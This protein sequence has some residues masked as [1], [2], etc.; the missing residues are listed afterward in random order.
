M[1][2]LWQEARSRLL[3]ILIHIFVA[4]CDYKGKPGQLAEMKTYTLET[5]KIGHTIV[6]RC[7]FHT[8]EC[9]TTKSVKKII[10]CYLT[11]Y[12]FPQ[13]RKIFNF[14]LHLLIRAV[15]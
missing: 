10:H 1:C 13:R 6:D 8:S 4:L 2:H 11:K 3:V 9:F 14:I 15:L 12:T 7:E 5:S